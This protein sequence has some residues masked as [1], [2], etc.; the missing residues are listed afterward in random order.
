[1][2]LTQLRRAANERADSRAGIRRLVRSEPR[3]AGTEDTWRAVQ[4]GVHYK[5]DTG[6]DDDSTTQARAEPDDADARFR[7][8]LQV[9]V[10]RETVDEHM[11][12][13]SMTSCPP[14]SE[15]AGRGALQVHVRP[16]PSTTRRRWHWTHVPASHRARPPR[17]GSIWTQRPE[18]GARAR[19]SSTAQAYIRA[20]FVRTVGRAIDLKSTFPRPPRI[21]DKLHVFHGTKAVNLEFVVQRMETPF[22]QVARD[23]NRLAATYLHA[24]D[25]K[26]MLAMW[27]SRAEEV[28]LE[29]YADNLGALHRTEQFFATIIGISMV[30][31]KLACHVLQHELPSR[32]EHLTHTAGLVTRALAQ[33]CASAKFTHVVQLVRDFGNLINHD[34]VATYQARFSLKSLRT[35]CTTKAFDNHT[36]ILDA[37]F[38]VLRME[39][40]GTLTDFYEEIPLVVHCQTVSVDG[41][42]KEMHE[43]R[44]SHVMVHSVARASQSGGSA[45]VSNAFTHFSE[46]VD[47]K[48]DQVQTSLDELKRSTQAFESWFEEDARVVLDEHV[49][50][51]VYFALE[52]KARDVNLV[53]Q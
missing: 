20:H 48:L 5:E 47:A 35:M 9:G 37:F 49:K 3:G 11:R 51:I 13:E 30:K 50:A 21:P 32:A 44:E 26:T 46:Q 31:Q 6:H 1:M 14:L 42:T 43:L 15:A 25:I 34:D 53:K 4:V 22:D 23:L 45:G 52:A 10:P 39:E 40:H 24:T 27:P 12:L 7:K 19:L 2:F 33:V 17:H 41:L 28:A 8:M 16:R 29:A 38:H 18:Q 36:T